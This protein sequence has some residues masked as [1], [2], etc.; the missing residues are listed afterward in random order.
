M[1]RTC[2]LWQFVTFAQQQPV[3]F[4]ERRRGGSEM[5]PTEIVVLEGHRIDS[6]TLAKVLASWKLSGWSHHAVVA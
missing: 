3:G 6:L 4:V 5:S 1:H 2:R